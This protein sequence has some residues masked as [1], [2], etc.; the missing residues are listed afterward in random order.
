M[1]VK[2]LTLNGYWPVTLRLSES[3]GSLE[4]CQNIMT[5][6]IWSSLHTVIRKHNK[7]GNRR[8][9]TPNGKRTDNVVEVRAMG[10]TI[11]PLVWISRHPSWSRL[12]LFQPVGIQLGWY[13]RRLKWR[14]ESNFQSSFPEGGEWVDFWQV[15]WAGTVRVT[16]TSRHVWIPITIILQ[17]IRLNG[18]N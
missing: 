13:T 9:A 2:P 5:G 18:T 1:P 8:A 10:S 14:F 16:M 3:K 15:Q 12:L 6:S 11:L 4:V 17:P 7:L